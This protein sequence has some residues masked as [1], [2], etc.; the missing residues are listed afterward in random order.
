MVPEES[1]FAGRAER[2]RKTANIAANF[3]VAFI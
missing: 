1:A 2:K 3:S